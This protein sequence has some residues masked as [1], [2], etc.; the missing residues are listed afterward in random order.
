MIQLARQFFLG[1]ASV[2]LAPLGLLPAPKYRITV[3]EPTVRAAVAGDFARV[4]ADF[5]SAHR[6]IE[7]TVQMEMEL[8]A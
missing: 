5:R 1:A 6:K 7:K 8:S 2:V 3:P 4:A